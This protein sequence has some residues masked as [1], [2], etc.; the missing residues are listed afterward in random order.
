[1]FTTRIRFVLCP[2]GILLAY[3]FFKRGQDELGWM[4]L[5]GTTLM[6]WGYFTN[7]T[8][9][10]AFKKIRKQDYAGAEKILRQ[11]RFPNQLTGIQKGFYHFANALVELNKNHLDEAYQEFTTSLSSGLRP[12]NNVAAAYLHMASIDLEKGR[13]AQA[14]EN[15]A[16]VKRLK[17]SDQLAPG[18]IKMEEQLNALPNQDEQ[19]G[20]G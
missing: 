2:W 18:I 16:K 3:F 15:L 19:T 14:R 8:V 13:I 1:M 17:Y 9:Y 4:M 7:G 5:V 10:L 20:L 6:V 11:T 12:S